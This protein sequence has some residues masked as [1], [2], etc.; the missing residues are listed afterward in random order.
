MKINEL[1]QLMSASMNLRCILWKELH[2]GQVWKQKNW[3]IHDTSFRGKA[4]RKTE[5]VIGKSQ[6]GSTPVVHSFTTS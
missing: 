2:T 5:E 3:N 6:D 4:V 1:Q